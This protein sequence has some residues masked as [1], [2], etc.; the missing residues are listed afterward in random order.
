M[1][2]I[3]KTLLIIFGFLLAVLSVPILLIVFHDFVNIAI[4]IITFTGTL[5]LFVYECYHEYYPIIHKEKLEEE[6]IFHQFHGD[7][8]KIRFYKG[9]KK[10]F[11]GDLDAKGL[12]KY[13][14]HH[15][16]RD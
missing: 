8:E 3:T 16:H 1:N 9:F 4:V 13:F 15:P 5:C 2:P 14:L 7:P 10:Y 12:E 11:D 6:K